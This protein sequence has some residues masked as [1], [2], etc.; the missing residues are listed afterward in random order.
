MHYEFNTTI[1]SGS[2]VV[3]VTYTIDDGL[4]SADRVLFNGVNIADALS[5][6]QLSDLDME[7]QAH[8]I[9]E[10][11]EYAEDVADEA[12]EFFRAYA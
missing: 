9:K 5:D 2:A 12:S 3:T 10:C 4:A 1:G 8:Y 7:C 6:D 11:R